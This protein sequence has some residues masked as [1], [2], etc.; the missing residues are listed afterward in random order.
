MADILEEIGNVTGSV[1][2]KGIQIAD[3]LRPEAIDILS[4]NPHTLAEWLI[5]I[6]C[7]P[8]TLPITFLVAALRWLLVETPM[9]EK[10]ILKLVGLDRVSGIGAALNR[11]NGGVNPILGQIADALMNPS[12]EFDL[13]IMEEAAGAVTSQGINYVMNPML[14][15]IGFC[16]ERAFE[17]NLINADQA[18]ALFHKGFLDQGA[19]ADIAGAY[20]YGGD[21][22]QELI[23]LSRE[24]PGFSDTIN[25]LNRGYIDSGTA[26]NWV[27]LMGL[28]PDIADPLINLRWHVPGVGDVMGFIAGLGYSLDRISQ[29]GLDDEYPS[30]AD[31]D[32][33]KQ[34]ADERIG[35]MAWRAHWSLPDNGMLLD[36]YH[37]RM[38]SQDELYSAMAVNGIPPVM[39]PIVEQQGVTLPMRRQ[40]NSMYKYGVI[41]QAY[42]HDIYLRY[43]FAEDDA[44]RLT[45]LA[46][47][48]VNPYESGN[49]ASDATTAYIDS[50]IDYNTA[51]QYLIQSGH[52]DFEATLHLIGA[53]HQKNSA[54]L[55]TVESYVHEPVINGD[56]SVDDAL[57][58]V[59]KYGETVDRASQLRLL[60]QEELSHTVKHVSEGDAR[61]AYTIGL[62]NA[63]QLRAFLEIQHYTEDDISV[64]IALE[65]A[66]MQAPQADVLAPITTSSGAAKSF[67][68]AELK[69]MLVDGVITSDEW[70]TNMLSLGYTDAQVQAYAQELVIAAQKTTGG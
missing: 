15:P 4:G 30:D 66:T 26:Y 22:T 68:K 56:M 60:W 53:D 42:V 47:K 38:I 31:V 67:T 64:I 52:S 35:K 41:D 34:G 12:S 10:Q 40:I 9:I 36:A 32:L 20:G 27:R 19:V 2:D 39:R 49:L 3:T 13:G 8:I 5:Y 51:K 28:D 11:C 54:L 61:S 69:K 24:A 33:S 59:L 25:L 37:R 46:A 17:N 70:W 65:N 43:G 16:M 7:L 6:L 18:A 45:L 21:V 48:A 14:R 50:T 57:N 23:D 58:Y 1:A 44:Q 62:I 55:K 63:T 29:F